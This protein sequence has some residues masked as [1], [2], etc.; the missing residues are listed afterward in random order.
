MMRTMEVPMITAVQRLRDSP[1]GVRGIFAYSGHPIRGYVSTPVSLSRNAQYESRSGK[2][3]SE[4]AYLDELSGI[5]AGAPHEGS[6]D[7]GLSHDPGD[8]VTFDGTAV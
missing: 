2:S 5:E 8:V 3:L 6:V 1:R 4:P 7:V